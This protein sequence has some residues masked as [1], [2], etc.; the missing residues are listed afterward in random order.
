M[1]KLQYEFHQSESGIF[2]EIYLPKKCYF[3]KTLYNALTG[4]FDQEHVEGCFMDVNKRDRIVALMRRYDPDIHKSLRDNYEHTVCELIDVK[5]IN[6]IG[7]SM[8]EVDGVF[9]NGKILEEERTQVIRIMFVPDLEE[10]LVQVSQKHPIDSNTRDK[11]IKKYLSSSVSNDSDEK[12]FTKA[13]R[14]L[15][16]YYFRCPT[17]EVEAA[18]EHIKSIA[19]GND[20]CWFETKVI[21]YVK[22]WIDSVALFLF[23]YI[24]HEICFQISKLHNEGKLNDKQIQDQIWVTSLWNLSVNRV[25]PNLPIQ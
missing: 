13:M 7:Y 21:Q 14:I 2:I 25:M 5:H 9:F 1:P 19:G 23:G 12:V 11:L 4:G 3:Q 18:K 20:L 22:K 15:I 17:Q 24:V 10:G 8:Y 16:G 6:Y